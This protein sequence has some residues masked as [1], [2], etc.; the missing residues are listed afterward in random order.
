MKL[1]KILYGA[2]AVVLGAALLAG[3]TFLP[4]QRSLALLQGAKTTNPAGIAFVS[5]QSPAVFSLLVN[6]DRLAEFRQAAAPLWK[7]GQAT[8]EVEQLEQ[9]LL[10]GAGLD[11]QQDIQPWLGDEITF[12]LPT[13]DLDRVA[14]NGQQPGYLLIAATEDAELSRQFLQAFWQQRAIAG[15]DLVFEEYKGVKLI[16]G[17]TASPP[18]AIRSRQRNRSTV[19]TTDSTIAS[20]VVGD[21]FVLFANDPRLLREAINNVQAPELSLAKAADYNTALNNLA[22]PRI[23]LAFLDVP[24]LTR[25]LGQPSVPESAADDEAMP[26][27]DNLAIGVGLNRQGLLAELALLGSKTTLP[28][29]RPALTQPAG[30]LGYLPAGSALSIAGKNLQQLWSQLGTEEQANNA[31]FKLIQ[32]PL[33]DLQT[34]LRISL[35]NEVFDWVKEDYAFSLL[36]SD[37]TN[38]PIPQPANWVFATQ[39]SAAAKSGIEHLDEIASQQGLSIGSLDL[40]GQSVVAWTRLA[41]QPVSQDTQQTPALSATVQGLH[42]SQGNYEIFATS[43]EAMSAALKTNKTSLLTSAT[44]KRAIAPLPDANDGYLYLDWPKSRQL[45]EQRFPILTL[46]EL[47]GKPVFGNLRSITASGFGGDA[48]LYRSQVFI[49]FG[50]PDS[51]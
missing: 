39:R 18:A 45:L 3:C 28:A 41:A 10:A 43:I 48:G 46:V 4:G 33:V 20:A 26:P 42:A 34:K 9:T 23:G 40:A 30:A 24:A 32:Q 21:R 35:A 8:T 44:F 22:A 50:Q 37:R 1:R 16:Y 13:L 47:A 15:T 36:P 6:P 5:K 27:Y 49:R 38:D 14:S 51:D 7:R 2:I 17:K 29:T 25:W 19:P 12:A 11:Y 31:L